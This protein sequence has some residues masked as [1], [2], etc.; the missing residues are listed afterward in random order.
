V[1]ENLV[2]D[3]MALHDGHL[4]TGNLCTKYLLEVLSENGQ[5]DTAFHL[6]TQQT[7]PSWGYMLA[8]GATTLWERWENMTGGGMNSHNHPMLGSIGSWFYKYL[9]GLTVDPSAP[10]F[11]GF[12]IRPCIPERLAHVYAAL[13]TVR[14]TIETGWERVDGYLRLFVQVPVGSRARISIPKPQGEQEYYIVENKIPVWRNGTPGVT[15]KDILEIQDEERYVTFSVGSGRY[16]FL[17]LPYPA[18]E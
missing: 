4:T 12:N 5:I 1:I 15:V 8:N 2:K 14:G 3:V 11:A 6:A 16:D 10:A 9:A 18:A 17:C 7:Y 13:N